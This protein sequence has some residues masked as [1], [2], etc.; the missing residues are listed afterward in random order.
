MS[1]VYSVDLDE[2]G[3][4]GGKKD[5]S[6]DRRSSDQSRRRPPSRREAIFTA[7]DDLDEL[8]ISPLSLARPRAPQPLSRI[9][10]G[11]S[12]RPPVLPSVSVS[13]ISA[14][15]TGEGCDGGDDARVLP[16]ALARAE[17][18][19]FRQCMCLNCTA[20]EVDIK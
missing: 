9:S 5:R 1:V 15:Q 12:A 7:T 11:P 18:Q 17:N 3:G 8:L 16:A 10:A 14:M 20:T 2:G 4:S 13:D 19:V 6:G